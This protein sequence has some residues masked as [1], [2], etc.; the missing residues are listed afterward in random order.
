MLLILFAGFGTGAT[1]FNFCCMTPGMTADIHT[2]PV[3][4]ECVINWWGGNPVWLGD[5]WLTSASYDCLLPAR[6]LSPSTPAG[7]GAYMLR[8]MLLTCLSNSPKL[9]AAG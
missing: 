6:R 4:D 5:R 3:S 2:H 8:A 1:G 7:N 9:E